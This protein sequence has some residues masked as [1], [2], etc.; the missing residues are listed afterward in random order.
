MRANAKKRCARCGKRLKKGGIYYRLNAELISSFD[1]HIQVDEKI[2]LEERIKEIE[3]KVEGL[4]ER[5]M[6]EQ[7]YKRFDYYICSVCRDTI[8]TFLEP[9]D[10][11]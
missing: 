3:E 2:D 11:R 7:V 5:E 9:G 1:G 10:G 4:T 8:D 6:E